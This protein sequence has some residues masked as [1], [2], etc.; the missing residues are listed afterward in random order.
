MVFIEHPALQMADTSL[1]QKRFVSVVSP[2]TLMVLL[3]CCSQFDMANSSWTFVVAQV[4][5][6]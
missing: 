2:F 6:T 5:S 4:I 3:S 1:W